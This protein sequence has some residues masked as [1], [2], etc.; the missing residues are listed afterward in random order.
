MRTQ[1]NEE[2]AKSNF[3]IFFFIIEF[4]LHLIGQKVNNQA[5]ILIVITNNPVEQRCKNDFLGRI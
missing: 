3:E 2:L 5:G 4:N 1:I